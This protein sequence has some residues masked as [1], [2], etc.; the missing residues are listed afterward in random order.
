MASNPHVLA[1]FFPPQGHINPMIQLCNRLVSKGIRVTF[2]TTASFSKNLEKQPH[3]HA[4]SNLISIEAVPDST[5]DE[6]HE[7]LDIYEAFFRSFRAAMISGLSEIVAKY[8]NSGEPL[9]AIVYD[10]CIPWMLDFAHEKGLKGAVLFTQ[11]ASVCSVFHHVYKGS[12][13]IS[14]DEASEV[15]LPGLPV[16]AV[17]DLP[18]LLYDVRGYGAILR[19]LVEQFSTFEKADWR[20]FNTFDK[21]EDEVLKWMGKEC[22]IQTIGPTVPSMYTDK[23]IPGNYDYGLCFF[24][25]KTESFIKWLDSKEDRSV[26]YV[27]F[28]SLAD[29]SEKQLEEVAWGLIATKCNFL[30]VVRDTE[31]SKLPQYL[32]SDLVERGL[33]VNWC[34]QLQVLSHRAVGGFFSH[35]GWN[36]TL[37]ALVLEVPMVVM[38]QWADQTTNAKLIVDV[39]KT[40]LRVK[41]DGN[42]IV[43]RDEV[44][45]RLNEVMQRERGD[46]IRRNML[47]WKDLAIEAV[48]EGG[49]SDNNITKFADELFSTFRNI[50]QQKLAP[51]GL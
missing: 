18:S 6:A 37:E 25:P 3:Q 34:T 2:G 1:I 29:L 41:A 27:S 46:E 23:R 17:K 40:G 10:S 39:W 28:G 19:T 48:S 4:D 22:K 32:V 35:C 36:S 16:L 31:Q 26:I 8:S 15:S 9:T 14:H 13:E 33:I 11:P 12:L 5:S 51:A 24:K 7:G 43:T 30:W 21:L 45:A 47:K 50:H 20:L 38:P 44:A 42:G 49:S